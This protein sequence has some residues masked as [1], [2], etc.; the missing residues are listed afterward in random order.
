M[1]SN[2]QRYFNIFVVMNIM[3]C[4]Y[5]KNMSMIVLWV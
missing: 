3:F 1:D 4:V 2:Y 5:T